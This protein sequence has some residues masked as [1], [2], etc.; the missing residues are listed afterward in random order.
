MCILGKRRSYSITDP[1]A[2]AMK[3]KDDTIK[4][5]YNEGVATEN[6]LVLD[7]H[8]SNTSGD[9]DKLIDLAEGVKENTGKTPESITADSAYGSEKNYE[10]MKDN[11][12]K[13][14]VKY[15]LY[16]PEKNKK[17]LQK[18]LRPSELDINLKQTVIAALK[19]KS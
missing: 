11:N 6:G 3:Q 15:P 5:G 17:W 1:D 2:T 9:A 13:P 16:H 18:R 7:Y 8:I 4:A 12:I 19:A 14:N 10:Y